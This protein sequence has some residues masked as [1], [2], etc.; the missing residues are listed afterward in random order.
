MEIEERL[1][2]LKPLVD[3][4]KDEFIFVQILQRRKDNPDLDIGVRRLKSYTFYSWSELEENTERIQELCDMNNARAYV[5]LNKQNASDVSLR[6]IEQISTNLRMGTPQNNRNVW[7]SVSGQG[8][9]KDWWVLDLDAEHLEY[10]DH[11]GKDLADHFNERYKSEIDKIQA[12]VRQMLRD[13]GSDLMAKETEEIIVSTQSERLEKYP[14]IQNPTKS[15]VHLICKPFDTRIL[16][17]YNKELGSKQ[18]QTIQIQK[19]ANTVLYI[20]NNNK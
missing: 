16:D 1:K 6:C 8:G 10:M 14:I 5:R 3:F 19:D 18:L 2:L 9:K 4:S 20:G 15:G 11:I 17:K 13:S 12:K 7:D